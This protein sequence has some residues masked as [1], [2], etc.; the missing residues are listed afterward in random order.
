MAAADIILTRE[1]AV[2]GRGEYRAR[3]RRK[4]MILVGL[5]LALCLSFAVDLAWGPARY[6]L[7]QVILAL[8]DP[9]AV[10]AQ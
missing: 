3:T 5:S 10:S 6:G 9:D 7:D 2:Q 8:I 1:A 4:I